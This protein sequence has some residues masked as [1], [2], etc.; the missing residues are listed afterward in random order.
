MLSCLQMCHFQPQNKWV[1]YKAQLTLIKRDR[2]SFIQIISCQVEEIREVVD[3][4]LGFQ[5]VE[6][7]CPSKTK[8]FLFIS[9]D[10]KV[11][12]CLIAEHIEEVRDD[13]RK[14]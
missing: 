13:G 8:T 11:A 3:S 4:D 5:Q 1:T 12:G 6:T 7:K 14:V 9:S 10:K 2:K